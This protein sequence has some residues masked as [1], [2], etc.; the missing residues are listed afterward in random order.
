M[1]KAWLEAPSGGVT[2]FIH[3]EIPGLAAAP[4]TGA[5][6]PHWSTAQ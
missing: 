5:G 1:G 3:S 4:W 2:A 6:P